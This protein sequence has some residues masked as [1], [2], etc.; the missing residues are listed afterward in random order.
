MS[1]SYTACE[2]ITKNTCYL[3]DGKLSLYI[4]GSKEDAESS[5]LKKIEEAMNNGELN[6]AHD[7]ITKITYKEKKDNQNT[8]TSTTDVWT[9]GYVSG[10]V[11]G[12]LVLFSSIILARFLLKSPDEYDDDDEDGVN[13][14]S[15]WREISN[16]S[17][18]GV[19]SDDE[20]ILASNKEFD[21]HF[22]GNYEPGD[23][24]LY[25]QYEN[26][27]DYLFNNNNS[28]NIDDDDI[29]DDHRDSLKVNVDLDSFEPKTRE[30]KDGCFD[31]FDLIIEGTGVG[32]M[33]RRRNIL[34]ADDRSHMSELSF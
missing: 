33:Q 30:E 31:F 29:N 7:A 23:T 32:G 16:T 20:T 34:D 2:A 28:D 11:I 15:I 18:L 17:S 9:P 24:D 25:D 10:I 22:E 8:R 27:E 12:G 13:N 14:R 3:L 26:Y 6:N 1:I 21:V 5:F 19:S 4:E